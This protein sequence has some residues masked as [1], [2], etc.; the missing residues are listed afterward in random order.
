MNARRC[1]REHRAAGAAEQPGR[2]LRMVPT[3]RAR[4]SL[5]MV[6]ATQAGDRGRPLR[7]RPRAGRARRGST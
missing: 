2:P 4:H 5:R 7:G 6:T 1:R 3:R